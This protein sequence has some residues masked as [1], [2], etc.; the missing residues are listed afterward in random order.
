M[1]EREEK[2]SKD[3][4]EERGVKQSLDD[5]D[6][7]ANRF[8]HRSEQMAAEAGRVGAGTDV[9]QLEILSLLEKVDGIS[10][11]ASS[12]EAL[13]EELIKKA[14]MI[15]GDVQEARCVRESSRGGLLDTH[16]Q[17]IDRSQVG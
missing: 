16:M 5:W 7:Y 4:S 8:R 6:E 3:E 11:D 12:G 1:G 17:E 13:D 14:R 15:D 10:C 2:K 9:A